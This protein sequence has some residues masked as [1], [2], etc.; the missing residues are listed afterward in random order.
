[1]EQLRARTLALVCLFCSAGL[2]GAQD[3]RGLQEP[4]AELSNPFA[5]FETHHLSNGVKVWFKRLAGVA[6][7]SVSAGIAVGSRADPPGKEQL[8]HFTEH[9]LFSDHDGRTEQE[10]KD[11]VE[12]LGGRRNGFTY[13]DHTYYY[14][15][16]GKEHGLF[17]IEWLA[18]IMSPHA[19]GT[20]RPHWSAAQPGLAVA[21]RLLG[22]RIRDRAGGRPESL[23]LEDPARDHARGSALVLR[24]LLRAGRDD[25]HD[26]R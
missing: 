12:G 1:M 9:M 4:T 6:N 22:A 2:V 21:A 18:G 7:V 10:I 11:A 20:L 16:I 19:M 17:A 24:S 13:S 14:V 3:T 26:H 23:P 8:A 5:G 25:R 15:T